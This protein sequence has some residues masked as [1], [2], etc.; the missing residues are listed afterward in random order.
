LP[1]LEALVI[2]DVAAELALSA[3]S[4]PASRILRRAPGLAAIAAAAA[5]NPAASISRLIAA[6]AILSIVE[7]PRDPLDPPLLPPPRF[8]LPL[9]ITTTSLLN[10]FLRRRVHSRNGSAR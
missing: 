3:A 1:S 5:V 7:L 8:E 2:I 6:F 10:A 9:A 4:R